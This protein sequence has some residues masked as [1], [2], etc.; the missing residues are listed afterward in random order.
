MLDRASV[1]APDDSEGLDVRA[2]EVRERLGLEVAPHV[3]DRIEFGR[4]RREVEGVRSGARQ[5]VADGG[6][7]VRVGAIP[8]QR[9]RGAQMPVEL[10]AEGQHR[11]G[12]EVLLDERLKVQA[13]D[14]AAGTDTERRDHRDFAAVAT[15]VPEHRGLAAWPPRAAHHGQQEQPALVDEDQPGAQALGFFLMRGQSCLIQRRMPSS[16][17]SSARRVGRCGVQPSARSTRPM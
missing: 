11:R 15:D 1:A 16:S 4:V 12:I 2:R 7:A 8:H 5:E 13:D 14:A 6:R 9:H 10:L 3:L 17:R